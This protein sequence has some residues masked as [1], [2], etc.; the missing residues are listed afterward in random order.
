MSFE[1]T[2][3]HWAI[4]NRIYLAIGTTGATTAAKDGAVVLNALQSAFDQILLNT[5]KID[6]DR[7]SEKIPLK[8]LQC[9]EILYD[10]VGLTEEDQ[11]AVSRFYSVDWSIVQMFYE[12]FLLDAVLQLAV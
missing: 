1:R 5:D 12:I 8:L 10:N 4:L 6:E 3:F 9:I 2:Q 11:M 7:D